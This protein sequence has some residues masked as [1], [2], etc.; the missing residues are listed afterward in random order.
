MAGSCVRIAITSRCAA[1]K[2]FVVSGSS[3]ILLRADIIWPSPVSSRCQND[4]S[5]PVPTSWVFRNGRM[6][7]APIINLMVRWLVNNF[8]LMFLALFFGFGAWALSTLQ[9][10]P[11][12]E[13][14]ITVRVARMGENQLGSNVWSGNLPTTVT[15]AVRAPRSVIN[16]LTAASLHIDVDLARRHPGSACPLAQGGARFWSPPTNWLTASQ[17]PLGDTF[18]H[19][20][21]IVAA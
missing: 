13:D 3:R 8:G 7:I 12:V 21:A 11:I 18:P 16:R 2:S 5:R 10:D 19:L 14:R 17:R 15:T 6:L 4:K 9:D 1:S 20:M